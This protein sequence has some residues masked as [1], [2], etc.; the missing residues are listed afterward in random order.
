M[1][2]IL[3][4]AFLSL[5]T[6]LFSQGSGNPFSSVTVGFNKFPLFYYRPVFGPGLGDGAFPFHVSANIPFN[7]KISWRAGLNFS[8]NRIPFLRGDNFCL[9][10]EGG[11][12]YAFL[13]PESRWLV[14]GSVLLFASHWSE[15]FS[16]ERDDL[17]W[18]SIGIGPEAM[19][20]YKFD[21]H[22]A[23]CSAVNFQLGLFDR[24]PRFN[25]PTVDLF[26]FRVLS[27]EV[28]YSF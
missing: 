25:E 9:G 11:A 4:L 1:K 28:R 18:N 24:G 6:F 27:A 12:E 7:E 3:T 16:L 15:E 19:V 17:V 21:E 22:W 13:K 10:L 26:S 23:V 8:T 14:N 5:S 2:K 20:G